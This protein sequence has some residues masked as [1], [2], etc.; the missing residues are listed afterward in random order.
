MKRL[1]TFLFLSFLLCQR[2]GTVSH[3]HTTLTLAL[4]DLLCECLCVTEISLS[5]V[6]L[7]LTAVCVTILLI[8]MLSSPLSHQR[9]RSTS[10]RRR[11]RRKTHKNLRRPRLGIIDKSLG[12]LRESEGK[13]R[14]PLAIVCLVLFNRSLFLPL[15]FIHFGLLLC[16]FTGHDQDRGF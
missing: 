16:P 12:K 1:S 9:R 15:H 2:C 6:P 10:R 13:E 14:L 5:R 4:P 3:T 8:L 7:C 11:R